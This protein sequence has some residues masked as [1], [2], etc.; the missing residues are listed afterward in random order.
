MLRHFPFR[1][2]PALAALLLAGTRLPAADSAGHPIVAGF[3]RFYTADK[4]DAVQGGRLLLGELNCVSCHQPGASGL[5]RKQAPIL[6]DVA[7]RV[8][9]GY[10]KKFLLD[11]HTVKPGGTM[12]DLFA[13]DPEKPAKVEALVHF[14]AS[15]GATMRQER[16]DLKAVAVGRDLYHKVGC[17]ACHG[18]RDAA[19]NEEKVLSSSVRLGDLKAKYTI[20]SLTAFLDNPQHVRPSGR[21]PHLVSGKEAKDVATYLLQGIKVHLSTAKGAT[22]YHY[23]EGS[24]DRLPDFDKL[25]PAATGTGAA[26]DLGIARRG[27]NYGV[28]FE[29]F[30]KLEKDGKYSFTLSSDDGSR[31]FV[32][33]KQVVDNDGTHPPQAHTGTAT[34]TKGV[35]KVA[36]NF[37]QAGGGAE[38]EVQIDGP[39]LA[40]Q[41]LGA[42]VGVTEAAIDKPVT[43]PKKT[44]DEDYLEIQPQLVEK[45]KGLF[46]SAGCASCH[47][48]TS[49]RKPLVSILNAPELARLK[50]EGGCLAPL[51]QP[52]PPGGEGRVRG[53]LP[54]YSL[55]PAQRHALAAAIKEQAP[56]SKEPAAVIARTMI[57]F[58]CYACHVRDKVG[59]HAEEFN[60]LVQT[61]QPEM[62]DEARV[63]PPLDGVGAKL[64]L[65]YV[66]QILDRGAHDRPYML[67]R[68]PGFGL[69]NVGAIADSFAA[70]DKLPAAPAVSFSEPLPKVKKAARHMV[71]G[72]AFGCIKCH[73][74]AGHKAEGVQG[75]DMTLMTKRLQR[76]WFH[77]YLVDP[78][79]IRPGTRMP[80]AWPN[81]QSVLPEVLD[82]KAETQIEAI[83]VYLKDGTG[84]QPPI[85]LG[86]HSIP[87]L[88]FKEAII[89]RNFIEGAGPRAIGVGYPEHANLAFDANE[90]RLAMIWQGAFIDA[91]RHWTD[92]GSGYE[93]PLGDDILHLH[94]GAA[95]AVLAKSD[96]AW[97]TTKPK[98]QGYK[99]HGYRLTPDERPTFLYSFGGVK[100][101][102]FPNAVAGKEVSLRRTLKL[103]AEKPVDKLYFRAAVGTKIE[104]LGD[105]WYRIDGWKMKLQ[106]GGEPH[107]RPAAGKTELLVPVPFKD[108]K[109]Q[110][111]QE[112]AW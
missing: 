111:V 25:K 21:M 78:Q 51:T 9:A 6:D 58:N 80:T 4:A 56:P 34:L 64:N 10:L 23:Y 52:S 88:P 104:A 97:P 29:G 5:A 1:W 86:G 37:F 66:K 89:Y 32:D 26:F 8:R 41:P 62:G 95:F 55:S 18:T 35:H 13:G 31:L 69:A 81:R 50:G 54:S 59:G 107:L 45:G 42:L 85:G 27:D 77:A 57:A 98:D 82:G 36:V 19:G 103:T 39:G 47:Q 16:P 43:P 91:G 87:L 108:G 101:E 84:A 75:I 74:F 46:T 49:D 2:L 44:D 93:G 15:S 94:G 71:G 110:V 79:K 60:K 28:K 73:T 22:T 99:F 38:L 12:P 105:G 83:W 70:L 20:P 53:G 67:T 3:E 30:F 68:M 40:G 76:D 92:R 33:G 7:A 61:A 65:E 14:L 17:V 24:W 109:A 102:D 11:P 90:M 72:Q 106:G 48:M 63:P 112:F 100:V 96:E